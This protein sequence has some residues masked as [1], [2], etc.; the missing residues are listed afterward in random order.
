MTLRLKAQGAVAPIKAL[1]SFDPV[2]PEAKRVYMR[3][4]KHPE[5][6]GHPPELGVPAW[7][8]LEE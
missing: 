2:V 1:T 4:F 6:K 8:A 3:G 7:K 5:L